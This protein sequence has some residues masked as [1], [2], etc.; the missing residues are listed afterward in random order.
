MPWNNKKYRCGRHLGLRDLSQTPST[1]YATGNTC[2]ALELRSRLSPRAFKTTK[3][4]STTETYY[5]LTDFELVRCQVSH[6]ED[7]AN[8]G[9]TLRPLYTLVRLS[10]HASQPHPNF[11]VLHQL[12]TR[13]ISC[14]LHINHV[15]YMHCSFAHVPDC[16]LSSRLPAIESR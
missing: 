1:F 5:A 7:V 2:F 12:S 9:Y 3:S 10:S 16:S 6:C 14:H 8:H 11:N 4:R 13:N 15:V